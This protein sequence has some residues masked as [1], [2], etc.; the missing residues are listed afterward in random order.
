M[1]IKASYI[2]LENVHFYAFHGVLPQ[3]KKVGGEFLVSL[4]A[5]CDIEL[6]VPLDDITLSVDYQKILELISLEMKIPGNLIENLAY[7]IGKRIFKEIPKVLEL[8]ITIEK[9]S[10]PVKGDLQ[11]AKVTLELVK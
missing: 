9:L 3:E 5:K 2:S 10:P 7:R 4:K 8:E 6:G 11:S 1:K